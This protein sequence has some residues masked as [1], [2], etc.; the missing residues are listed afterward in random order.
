[1]VSHPIDQAVVIATGHPLAHRSSGGKSS[2]RANGPLALVRVGGVALLKRAIL[3]LQREGV[4]RFVVVIADRA[5]RKALADDVQL[6]DLDIVWVRN[7][8]R[9]QED[10]Y[11]VLRAA[12]HIRGEFFVVHADRVFDP[13]IVRRL[14]QEPLDGLTLATTTPELA[15]TRP[16]L[17]VR[18][19]NNIVAASGGQLARADAI[20]VGLGAAN[21]LLVSALE[22]VRDSG[23]RVELEAAIAVMAA[24]G[25][26]RTADI[27]D[28]LWQDVTTRQGV[29]DAQAKLFGAL[30]KSVDGVIAR[31]INRRFSLAMSRILMHF[32]IRPN[33]VTAFSLAVSLAAAVVAAMA[34]SAEPLWLIAGA[35][36][37]QLA[38]M[39]D[40]IDGELARLKFQS[41]KFGEWFDTLTDDIGKFTFFIGAG[42]GLSAITGQS[43][44]FQ[45]CIVGVAIQF[46]LALNLYR[47][48]IKA[49]SGSHYA[50]AWE[51]KPEAKDTWAA[52]FYPKMEFLCRRDYYVFAFLVMTI[53]GLAKMGIILMAATTVW[54]LVHELLKPRNAR[55]DFP[56][57]PP[58][59]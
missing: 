56:V 10:G 50:L 15:G 23:E 18:L 26:A 35:G 11:S 36:L 58:A 54:V 5:V 37:W 59:S 17:R 12:P 43:I 52:R 6:R 33:H 22:R 14:L 3:T 53:V 39:L 2:D 20:H 4:R 42:Y 16:G 38:S 7:A 19:Q 9:P 48:L 51:T 25:T 41:S 46:T 31:H 40:G 27:G 45:L 55:E 1:M 29:R 24:Q 13:A 8:E 34:T 30:R 21:G 28:A 32:P 49:G 47:K 57:R 44:W